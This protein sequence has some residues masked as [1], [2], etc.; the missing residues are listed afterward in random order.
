MSRRRYP[1]ASPVEDRPRHDVSILHVAPKEPARETSRG[2]YGV[3]SA[4]AAAMM[5]LLPKVSG[6]AARTFG[7]EVGLL[8]ESEA[9]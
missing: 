4:S 6:Q 8:V 1:Q 2:P 9:R 5:S 7:G 3:G